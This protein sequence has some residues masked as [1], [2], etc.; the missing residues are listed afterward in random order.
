MTTEEDVVLH[1]LKLSNPIDCLKWKFALRS[2]VINLRAWKN[3]CM[4]QMYI[5]ETKRDRLSI[6][7]KASFYDQIKIEEVTSRLFYAQIV[8]LRIFLL[9]F[10]ENNKSSSNFYCRNN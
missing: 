1:T 4:E 6:P 5:E 9:L 10:I 7:S 3:A 8:K 2:A